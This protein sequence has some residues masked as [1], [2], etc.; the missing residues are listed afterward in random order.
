LKT[1][2]SA[3][4]PAGVWKGKLKIRSIF[5]VVN[6]PLASQDFFSGLF[7]GT[8]G[9][10]HR[11]Q[12]FV[13]KALHTQRETLDAR[14]FKRGNSGRSKLVWGGLQGNFPDLASGLQIAD[15]REQLIHQDSRGAA[16]EIKVLKGKTSLKIEVQF[17]PEID[18]ILA[19]SIF[20]EKVAVEAAERAK[21]AAEGNMDVE[22]KLLSRPEECRVDFGILDPFLQFEEFPAFPAGDITGNIGNQC[23][24]TSFS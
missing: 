24:F 7:T 9:P 4:K 23:G 13:I 3:A 12:H 6:C 16:A 17:L 19:G 11:F 14:S 8:K 15:E 22:R 10:S 21:F 5:S 18:E 20:L 1:A 2:T